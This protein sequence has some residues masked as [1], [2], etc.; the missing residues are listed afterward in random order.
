MRSSMYGFGAR[1]AGGDYRY[2]REGDA[3]EHDLEDIKHLYGGGT[4]KVKFLDSKKRF[5]R[6]LHVAIGDEFRGIIPLPDI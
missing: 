5:M 1:R 4:Y 3:T 2:L 6:T